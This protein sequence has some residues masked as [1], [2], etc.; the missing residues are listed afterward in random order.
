MYVLCLA[1]SIQISATGLVWSASESRLRSA[2]DG[3][4]SLGVPVRARVAAERRGV[5]R[6]S[7]EAAADEV[8]GRARGPAATRCAPSVEGFEAQS[9][10]N[11]R[12]R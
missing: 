11:A 6:L 10:P 3:V 9:G 12:A 4:P 7:R 8:G 5:F 1:A 2:T